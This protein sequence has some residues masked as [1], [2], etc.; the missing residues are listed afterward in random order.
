VSAYDTSYNGDISDV[1]ISK[2]A[3]GSTT[4][5]AGESPKVDPLSLSVWPNPITGRARIAF[6]LPGS[7]S[8]R[9]EVFDAAGRL[10]SS[11][12]DAPWG[13]GPHAL[14]WNA[15]DGSG[16]PLPAGVYAVRLMAGQ[17]T[18]SRSVVVVR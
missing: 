1:F 18:Q 5:I 14:D 7:A 9:I 2:V 10:R 3:L 8:A 4:G 17:W 16:R 15:L 11:I 13:A 12:P 6:T